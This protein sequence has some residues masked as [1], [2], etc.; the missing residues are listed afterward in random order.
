VILSLLIDTEGRW[1]QEVEKP[2]EAGG[3][4]RQWEYEVTGGGRQTGEVMPITLR[5]G[6]RGS[7]VGVP[8][9]R[10]L[11]PKRPAGSLTSTNQVRPH[12]E[13][14]GGMRSKEK[15]LPG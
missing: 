9:L 10:G 12:G 7:A 5:C 2:D 1:R 14:A 13:P 8:E 6:S 4:A 15:G 11:A 3:A